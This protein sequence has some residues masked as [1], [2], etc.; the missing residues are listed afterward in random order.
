MVA[1]ASRRVLALNKSWVPIQVYSLEKA[2]S[3]V[4]GSYKNGQ[5]KA[6][7]IDHTNHYTPVYWSDWTKLKLAV[8][9]SGMRSVSREVRIPEVIRLLRYDKLP[10][11]KVHYN[12]KTLFARDNRTCMYCGCRPPMSE[13]SID[14][15]VP[16]SR[17]GRTEWT[18]VVVACTECNARKADRLLSEC[19]M[20]LLRKPIKPQ[21]NIWTSGPPL[22]SWRAFI[23]DDL[24]DAVS[25]AYWNVPLENDMDGRR[26]R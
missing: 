16:R 5:A 22:E 4:C 11:N 8:G 17:G 15:V 19:G 26:Q 2:L 24:M 14:H 9:E 7:I 10:L 21:Y 3:K 6:E 25:E 1:L 20:K 23:G 12:R 13:L 18:N